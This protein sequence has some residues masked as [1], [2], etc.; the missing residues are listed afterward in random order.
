MGISF[1]QK[2]L[3]IDLGTA[4]SIVF[5]Q[6]EGMVIEEPTVVA[7]DTADLS[8]IA[9]GK[10]AKVMLGKTPEHIMIR[11]PLRNG[12]IASARVT[13]ELL[14]YFIMKAIGKFRI[15][16]PEIMIS[17]PVGITSVEKRAIIKA[18]LNAGAGKVYLIPE[19][20]AAAIG[21]RL[22]IHSSAGNMIVNMGGGTTEIA[23]I[24]LNGIVVATTVRFAGDALTMQLLRMLVKN[25]DS[26]LVSKWQKR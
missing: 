13:E 11:R 25:V 7:I 1:R 21:A 2:R 10:E 9:I 6:G 18:A 26:L 5:V 14:K 19:P 3:G 24:S 12:V 22:P 4:N 20:L 16:R 23:V 8:I 15:F 17:A